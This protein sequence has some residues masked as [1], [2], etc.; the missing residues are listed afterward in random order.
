MMPANSRKWYLIQWTQV[1]LNYRTP[2]VD[3]FLF[4]IKELTDFCKKNNVD[5][6]V[7]PLE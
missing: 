6:K 2:K 4:D 7:T 1:N 3:T 5:L